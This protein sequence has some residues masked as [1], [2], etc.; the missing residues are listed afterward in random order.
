MNKLLK[1][2]LETG[3]RAIDKV[4]TL[5]AYRISLVFLFCNIHTQTGYY[6]KGLYHL[7]AA[8]TLTNIIKSGQH[9]TE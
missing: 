7:V 3:T 6:K 2:L 8:T 9:L 4:A 5:K 1:K